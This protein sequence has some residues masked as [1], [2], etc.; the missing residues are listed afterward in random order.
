MQH[1]PKTACAE[2][3]SCMNEELSRHVTARTVAYCDQDVIL[4]KGYVTFLKYF[5]YIKVSP[6]FHN[7]KV[8]SL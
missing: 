3:D 6:S 5:A 2:S 8:D 7:C 1:Y 4:S